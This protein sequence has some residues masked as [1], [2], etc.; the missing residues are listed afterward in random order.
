MWNSIPDLY[1]RVALGLA[2]LTVCA[3]LFWKAADTR[4]GADS[5]IAII[6]R[7]Q[8]QETRWNEQVM[9]AAFGY[10]RNYDALNR[11]SDALAD[12][13][14]QL[15]RTSHQRAPGVFAQLSTS[16]D[17]TAFVSKLNEKRELAE[18][19]KSARAIISSSVT[20]LPT[21]GG[22]LDRAMDKNA[23][24]EALLDRIR[25]NIKGASIGLAA[26]AAHPGVEIATSLR[27]Q[28]E[29]L[30]QISRSVQLPAELGLFA[31]H[32]G[33][34]LRN[35]EV[36]SE[37]THAFSDIDTATAL[38]QLLRA[39][40]AR[41]A[42]C[43]STAQW[44]STCAAIAG[45]LCIALFLQ[46][47]IGSARRYRI[48][49]KSNDDLLTSKAE[50][51]TQLI[52][53]AKM[54]AIGQMVAGVAHEINTPLA[55]I[56]AT[57]EF[58]R[59]QI[60]TN[61]RIMASAAELAAERGDAPA[62]EK[63]A[64]KEAYVADISMLLDDGLHG[65]E[66]I[67]TLVMSLKNFSRLDHGK[68]SEFSVEDGLSSALAIAR[69]SIKHVAEVHT[70]FANVPRIM[71]SPSHINQ[72][73]LNI[74]MNA[75]QAMQGRNKTGRLEITTRETDNDMIV[76]TIT[77]DGPGMS[78]EVLSRIFDLYFTTKPPGQGSG[79][80]LAICYRIIKNHHGRI[81]V[82]SKPGIGTTFSVFLPVRVRSGADPSA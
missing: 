21:L 56:K 12:T 48:V 55:Y 58:L 5:A 3:L 32:I 35:T 77:D 29:T 71:G 18:R 15:S 63:E 28:I 14:H 82:Q 61:P 69:N 24:D 53:A 70:S 43:I 80:G 16:T 54:S 65:I 66:Q 17:F 51:E 76:V 4:D 75:A 26:Y 7:T 9:L 49:S 10:A 23:I 38:Q 25:Q 57:F 62:D 74:I 79:V 81:E 31:S 67:S 20:Y 52:Q 78:P 37:S 30:T 39:C 44:M 41:R 33:V 46:A 8:Q 34:V 19:M 64:V 2:L 42:Q 73:F 40:E 13:V 11:A 36:L 68:L 60:L 22:L 45:L 6:Q 72:V 47:A 59:D 50:V 1:L 27:T